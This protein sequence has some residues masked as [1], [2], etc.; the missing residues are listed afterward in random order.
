[1]WRRTELAGGLLLAV[2]GVGVLFARTA[3]VSLAVWDALALLFL[4]VGYVRVRQSVRNNTDE[5]SPAAAPGHRLAPGRR[6][7]AAVPMF[8][9]GIGMVAALDV[10]GFPGA[11][12]GNPAVVKAL[13]VL[14]VFLAWS[15]LQVGNAR[16]YEWLFHDGGGAGLSF[17]DTQDPYF[18]DF[19]YF[20]FGIGAT[21]ATSDVDITSR[22][23]RWHVLGHTVVSFFYNAIVLAVAFQVITDA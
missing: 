22:G 21:F 5:L 9:S 12:D 15:L 16:W 13:G 18:S 8:T 2:S 23:M 11:S 1:M 6:M 19:L 7:I 3:E 14:T 4:I 17:P 10:L 20:S